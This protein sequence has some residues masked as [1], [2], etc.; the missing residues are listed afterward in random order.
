MGNLHWEKVQPDNFEADSGSNA[1]IHAL[2][3]GLSLRKLMHNMGR[4]V[5]KDGNNES[6]EIFHSQLAG[7]N[8]A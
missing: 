2:P 4:R 5:R 3:P 7:M 1:P 6:T 8:T